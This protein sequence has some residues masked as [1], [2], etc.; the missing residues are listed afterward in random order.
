[1]SHRRSS[2]SKSQNSD[3]KLYRVLLEACTKGFAKLEVSGS[4]PALVLDN[5]TPP[6][7]NTTLPLPTISPRAATSAPSALDLQSLPA[8]P[9]QSSISSS[10]TDSLPQAHLGT[11]AMQSSIHAMPRRGAPPPGAGGQDACR[12]LPVQPEA[13]TSRVTFKKNAVKLIGPAGPARKA[14]GATTTETPALMVKA[15]PVVEAKKSE[16]KAATEYDSVAT[17]LP[18]PNGTDTYSHNPDQASKEQDELMQELKTNILKD[19]GN[20]S[21]AASILD[22]MFSRLKAQTIEPVTKA[23]KSDLLSGLVSVMENK[24]ETAPSSSASVTASTGATSH[25]YAPTLGASDTQVH[26]ANQVRNDEKFK[27]SLEHQ[28]GRKGKEVVLALRAPEG[29]MV[30]IFQHLTELLDQLYANKAQWDTKKWESTK[31]AAITILT[32]HFGEIVKG[33]NAPKAN[34]VKQTLEEHDGNF[35][36]LCATVFGTETFFSGTNELEKLRKAILD[37]DYKEVARVELAQGQSENGP[38]PPS[39]AEKWPARVE[40]AD[41]AKHRACVLKN[42]APIGNWTIHKLQSLVWGGRLEK[43][44]LRDPGSGYVYV[45]FLTS[46]ACQ[47]YLDATKN[48]FEICGQL[49]LVDKSEGPSS[50][51]DVIRHCIESGATRCIRAVGAD[52]DWSDL[53]L[54]KLARGI[55]KTAKREV[56]RV[57]RGVTAHGH[58]FIEF[59]FANIIDALAFKRELIDDQDW[60]HCNI[61]FAPD[62]C[63]LANGVHYQGEESD[64]DSESSA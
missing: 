24:G 60:E 34:L 27:N 3:N 40:R 26:T 19:V 44:S 42:I 14:P 52:E 31:D 16:P 50:T 55:A 30:Q 2:S 51:N 56:D 32:N 64:T 61:Q 33:S 22:D 45:K 8:S 57:L 1:M 53:M 43:I 62:P 36:F 10:S 18:R 15:S 54:M 48:G 12:N 4:R 20:K 58:H 23:T 39:T 63:E 37:L 5:K 28:I 59:R 17:A 46:E 25:V 38:T 6:S 49:V 9:L 47:K 41:A 7:P 11:P 35:L 29:S 21:A 13:P